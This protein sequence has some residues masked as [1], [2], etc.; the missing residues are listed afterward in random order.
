MVTM[1][2]IEIVL[3]YQGLESRVEIPLKVDLPEILRRVQLKN[4]PDPVE[5]A[6][7]Q[8]T[9]EIRCAVDDYSHLRQMLQDILR[10]VIQSG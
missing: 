9:G 8:L 1:A 10:Q 7:H 2:S 4:N 6:S 5:E 3:R